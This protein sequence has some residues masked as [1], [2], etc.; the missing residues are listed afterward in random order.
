M[1]FTWMC[2]CTCGMP[3]C[4]NVYFV[5]GHVCVCA[6]ECSWR[7][8]VG[9]RCLSRLHSLLFIE[10][11]SKIQ[12]ELTVRAH[13]ASLLVSLPRGSCLHLQNEIP[14]RLHTHW[15]IL[16]PTLWSSYLLSQRFIHCTSSHCCCPVVCYCLFCS[17]LNK[18]L[19]SECM[20]VVDFL[21]WVVPFV[22]I[23]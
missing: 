21:K 23:F 2:M 13:L 9:I 22:S 5:F 11:V 17:L 18:G 8:G 4:V 20:R 15:Q 6:H 19:R 16:R 1:L 10:A 7:P 14:G 3:E 12:P